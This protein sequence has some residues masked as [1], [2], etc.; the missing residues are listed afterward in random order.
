MQALGP[1]DINRVAGLVRPNRGKQR[2]EGAKSDNVGVK[3]RRNEPH[4]DYTSTTRERPLFS[5]IQAA[6]AQIDIDFPMFYKAE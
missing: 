6:I 3:R 5:Y 4:I 1:R 2:A